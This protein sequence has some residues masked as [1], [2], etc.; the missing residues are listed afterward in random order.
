MDRRQLLEMAA[1]ARAAARKLAVMTVT[2][3]KNCLLAMRGALVEGADRIFD[4]AELDAAD[5]GRPSPDRKDLA[6][7]ERCIDTV[8]ALPHPLGRVEATWLRPNGLKI[9]KVRVPIG[10]IGLLYE[11]QSAF[12]VSAM[13]LAL[14]SGNA[15]F[16]LC[17]MPA[18]RATRAIMDILNQAAQASGLAADILHLVTDPAPECLRDFIRLRPGI[19]ALVPRCN[20]ETMHILRKE[21]LVPI[22][23]SGAGI[24][25]VYVDRDADMEMALHIIENAKCQRPGARNS[26]ETVLVH[27]DVAAELADKLTRE[28]A[29]QG[30]ELRGDSAF[31]VLAPESQPARP[32]EWSREHCSLVLGVRIVDG[33]KQAL[34]HISEFGTGHSDAIITANKEQAATF[35]TA[36]DSAC[37]YV[38]ASPRFT[39]GGEFGMGV[40]LGV[41]TEHLHARGPV[42][43]EELTTYKYLVVG[44]GQ[45][46]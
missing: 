4:A 24:C 10:V 23:C 11:G 1:R 45:I 28:L 35:Q 44:N 34:D 41:S 14:K 33:L 46:R 38:N 6:V 16:G 15:A 21:A 37:V 22:L 17:R 12:T 29:P 27:Q 13:A 39:E 19:N 43:L 30:V 18:D 3:R 40:E 42:G 7:M 36:V 25:H 2:H 26:A 20:A 32:D 5:R 8:I 9:E 31:C